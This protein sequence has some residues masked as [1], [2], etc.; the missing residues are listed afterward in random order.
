M[1]QTTAVRGIAWAP[2]WTVP[3][4]YGDFHAPLYFHSTSWRNPNNGAI[5]IVRTRANRQAGMS[6]SWPVILP[7]LLDA[8]Y[9]GPVIFGNEPE[10]AE[11]DNT[12][13]SIFVNEYREACALVKGSGIWFVAGNYVMHIYTVKFANSGLRKQ[14]VV[15]M[16]FYQI[17]NGFRY[18]MAV[19]DNVLKQLPE[20]HRQT[21]WVTEYGLDNG[22]QDG[23]IRRYVNE[24]EQHP[25]VVAALAYT[26]YSD[27]V[28]YRFYANK[29][30]GVTRTGT[31][32]A[33]IA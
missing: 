25:A 5:P 10:L 21:I 30:R 20:R 22:W 17:W 3:Y 18:P 14:D 31:V 9:A 2:G 33:S 19:I 13:F 4:L 26:S 27:Q 7:Q 16:H 24:I 32:L 15:G 1:T 28:Q 6:G 29:E 8:R 23:Q 12:P 11:Q